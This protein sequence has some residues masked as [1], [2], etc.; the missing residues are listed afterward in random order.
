MTDRP[1]TGFS[2]ICPACGRRAPRSVEV[3]RCGATLGD[4]VVDDPA[5]IAPRSAASFAAGVWSTLGV[6]A[7]LGAAVG[8]AYWLN[9][10]EP[11]PEVRT[12]APAPAAGEQRAARDEPPVEASPPLSPMEPLLLGEREAGPPA[13]PPPPPPGPPPAA[14]SSLEDVIGGVMPAVVLVETST[15]RGSAFFVAPDTLLT[16]V[17]VVGSNGFVTIRRMSGETASARVETRAPQFDVAVLKLASPPPGQ[18]TIPLGA[19][20]S[21]RVGQEVIAIG[22]ALGTLQNTVTRGIVSALRRTGGATLVQ[23][24]AAI[25]PGNSGGPLL[26]RDG[27]AIGITTMGYTD[28]QGLNFAVAIDHARSV[29][30][31]RPAPRPAA[32]APAF[33]LRNLSPELPSETEQAREQGDRAYEAALTELAGRAQRLDADWLRFKESC[34]LGAVV[35]SFDRE[36][37]A[38]LTERALPGVVSPACAGYFSQFKQ[39]AEE[40]RALMLSTD[41][42]ARRMG[43]YPGTRRDAR[44]RHR[45]SHPAW[46]R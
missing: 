39:L 30:E 4:A 44:R 35:G 22:S 8:G 27:S 24:D 1:T 17:H 5:P 32:A 14:T 19:G 36:W 16:N 34:Y 3:C 41:E 21:V 10:P 42:E 20:A 31:G 12:A 45:V 46:D 37:F 9:R 18:P 29:L 43:V 28:R 26:A 2:R 40:F 6:V 13:L 7:A 23:T 33:D 15:G 38:L 25:N 11:A